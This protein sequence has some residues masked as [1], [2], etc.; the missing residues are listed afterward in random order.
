MPEL[1]D[2]MV[3]HPAGAGMQE[4]PDQFPV[5][6]AVIEPFESLEFLD[7]LVGHPPL[8]AYR[9]DLERL[10]EEAQHA[11]RLKAALE[12]AD[13][14][15]VGVGFLGPLAGG[16]LLQEHQ[17]A[18]EFI[19]LLHHVVEEQLGVVNVCTSHHSRGLPAAAPAENVLGPPGQAAHHASPCREGHVSPHGAGQAVR[20]T[21]GVARGP[22]V[23]RLETGRESYR[24][25]GLGSSRLHR[26]EH[27]L[28]RHATALG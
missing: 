24:P 4:D 27:R 21:I 17:W 20:K 22:I 2:A 26:G 11:L 8:S 6:K 13:R 19:A 10:R 1:L 28:L 15:G 7:A 25:G 16:T 14:F 5:P 18:D 3:A 9:D 23:A 12:G